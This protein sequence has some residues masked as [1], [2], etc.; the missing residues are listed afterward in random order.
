MWT[1]LEYQVMRKFAKE[2]SK[3]GEGYMYLPCWFSGD[4]KIGIILFIRVRIMKIEGVVM[5]G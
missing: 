1:L 4:L 5:K 3:F 2:L